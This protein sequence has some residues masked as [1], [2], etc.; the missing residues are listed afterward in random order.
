MDLMR[1]FASGE[2]VAIRNPSAVRP[3]QHVLD[4]LNGYLMLVPALLDGT[5]AGAWNFGPDPDGFR[6]VGDAA[7]QAAKQAPGRMLSRLSA[8]YS[9][10]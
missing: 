9:Q 5:G 4:C 8:Q 7:T 2:T 3:W 1:G 10:P 6:T